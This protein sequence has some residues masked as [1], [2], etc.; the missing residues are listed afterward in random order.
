MVTHDCNVVLVTDPT[1]VVS[2]LPQIADMHIDGD[3]FVFIVIN[4][5]GSFSSDY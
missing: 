4:T 5:E 2:F 1:E 3:H